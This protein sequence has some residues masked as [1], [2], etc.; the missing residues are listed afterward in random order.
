MARTRGLCDF[1]QLVWNVRGRP[2][3]LRSSTAIFAFSR[4]SASAPKFA[5]LSQR[6]SMPPSM[7][8]SK[9][10]RMRGR[11]NWR[12]LVPMAPVPHSQKAQRN[13]QPRLVS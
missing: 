1:D 12:I 3:R 9:S 4:S 6:S 13:G 2:V 7:R 5:S 8:R 10:L 11:P